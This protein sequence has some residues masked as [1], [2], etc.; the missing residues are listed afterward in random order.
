MS[1]LNATLAFIGSGVMGEAMI[2]GLLNRELVAPAQII[3]SDVHPD[4]CETLTAM[5]DIRATL[6]N[7]EAATG[8]R[9]APE[10]L[11]HVFDL[12]AQGENSLA[13]SEG[14]LG[15]G[16]TMVKR[17][18][19]LHGGTVTARSEGEGLGSEFVVRLPRHP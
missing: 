8:G 9:I 13:R 14:G 16:L 12:F 11:P 3:A 1:L 15:I 17:L 19:E 18:V 6:H 5:Y 4:R 2:K 7:A 10:F